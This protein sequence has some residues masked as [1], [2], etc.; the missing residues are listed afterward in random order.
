MTS[1]G[2][3]QPSNNRVVTRPTLGKQG[4]P[5]KRYRAIFTTLKKELP[6]KLT[7]QEGLIL[8]RAVRLTLMAEQAGADPTIDLAIVCRLENL[9]RR[10]RNEWT[11]AARARAASDSPRSPLREYLAEANR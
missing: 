2:A 11:N 5:S 7:T 1:L 6:R 10:A 4:L 3:V 8:H 9:S